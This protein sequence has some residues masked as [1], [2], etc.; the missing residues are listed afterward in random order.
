MNYALQSRLLETQRTSSLKWKVLLLVLG[1][2]FPAFVAA[3]NP[4]TR[5]IT[6]PI[7]ETKVVTL[8]G[9]VHPL[10]QARYDARAAPS[11]MPARRMLLLLNRPADREADLA[12]YM[13]DVH[14]PGS[15]IRHQWLT[16]EGF[17][18]RFGPA[19]SDIQQ[20]SDWLSGL[21]FQVAGT[22]KGKTLIEFSGTV[23]QVNNAFHTQIRKYA[24]N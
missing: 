2:A 19:D 17:G 3:Q 24:I 23:G 4:V 20:V 14:T 21:G 6:Q 22:S 1:S 11:S 13:K 8:H 5:L 7:N 15:T 16:P 10:A 9:N 12:E 18:A